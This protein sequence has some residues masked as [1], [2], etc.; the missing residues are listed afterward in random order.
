MA[1]YVAAHPLPDIQVGME[2]GPVQVEVT[3]VLNE[4]FLFAMEDY[5]S[6]YLPGQ[7][8]P[9]LAHPGTLLSLAMSG[10]AGF[11]PAEGW[12]GMHARDEVELVRP[13]FVGDTLTLRWQVA[14]LYDKRGRPWWV[15]ECTITGADGQLRLR[16][17]IHTAFQRDVSAEPA[18]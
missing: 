14:D 17:R 7:P 6:E 1:S 12:T 9:P 18:E 8:T 16:R 3:E 5:G 4:Q 11:R 10:I 13:V 15:R 2:W